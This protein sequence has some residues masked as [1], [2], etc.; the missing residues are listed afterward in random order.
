[1]SESQYALPSFPYQREM[2]DTVMIFLNFKL[3]QSPCRCGRGRPHLKEDEAELRAE[4]EIYYPIVR[5]RAN[6]ALFKNAIQ[7]FKFKSTVTMIIGCKNF[8]QTL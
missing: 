8:N 6:K 4:Y 3:E 5:E 7:R 2:H 1:M